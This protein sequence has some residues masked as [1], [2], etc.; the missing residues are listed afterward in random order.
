MTFR[1]CTDTRFILERPKTWT[2]LLANGMIA[3]SLGQSGD[4]Y[5]HRRKG[6]QARGCK[7]RM[8]RDPRRMFTYEV[9]RM[10]RAVLDAVWKVASIIRRV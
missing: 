9:D 6:R 4:G 1:V 8:L 2:A 7:G 5:G 10:T 3:F